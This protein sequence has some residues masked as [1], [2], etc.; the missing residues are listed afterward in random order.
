MVQN[1][2]RYGRLAMM[3]GFLSCMYT[4]GARSGFLAV[5]PVVKLQHLLVVGV[6]REGRAAVLEGA[7]DV[8]HV[9]VEG[10][11]Q[12]EQVQVRLEGDGLGQLR[13]RLF[14]LVVVHQH[15][16]PPDQIRKESASAYRGDGTMK[17]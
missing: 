2:H 4:V 3:R 12:V 5:H 15:C 8:A 16:T 9:L 14:L 13:D 6:H 10:R 11:A 1:I 17:R 7:R